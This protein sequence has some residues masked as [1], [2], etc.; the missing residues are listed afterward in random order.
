MFGSMFGKKL[1]EDIS[2]AEGKKRLDANPG[3]LLLDVRTPA[4]YADGHIKNSV[5]LPLDRLRG[6]IDAVAPDKD[7][8]IFVY[9]L[10]GARAANACTQLTAMG[11]THVSNMGGIQS[12]RYGV[13][14]G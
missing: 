1:Y 11:Y 12:W 14:R 10:S 4:E 7:Q 8:E 9:C 3:I 5:S 2:S 6:K 13:V